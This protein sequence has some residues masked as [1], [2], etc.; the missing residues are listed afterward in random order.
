M[1]FVHTL[2]FP[3]PPLHAFCYSE[4]SVDIFVHVTQNSLS[5][6]CC[7]FIYNFFNSNSDLSAERHLFP[8]VNAAL[9]ISHSVSTQA[10]LFR[11]H[12][13]IYKTLTN[14]MVSRQVHTEFVRIFTG[15]TGIGIYPSAT[16]VTDCVELDFIGW[17]G[18]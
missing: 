1:Q 13:A 10:A 3:I 2:L 8:S 17:G 7:K 15:S 6:L 12:E 16:A 18:D 5:V 9:S 11:F 4:T 14:I